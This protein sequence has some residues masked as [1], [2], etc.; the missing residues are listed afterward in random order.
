[1]NIIF[2]I[3]TQIIRKLRNSFFKYLSETHEE[4]HEKNEKEKTKLLSSSKIKE[5]DLIL[6]L[7]PENRL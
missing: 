1:M 6:N 2:C 4:F 5:N 3:S 7:T